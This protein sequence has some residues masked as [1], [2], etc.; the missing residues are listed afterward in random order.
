M[1]PAL[2][3]SLDS[4]CSCSRICEKL[5]RGLLPFDECPRMFCSLV[6]VGR[7]D[8]RWGGAWDSLVTLS[9]ALEEVPNRMY[10]TLR[11][12]ILPLRLEWSWPEERP[13]V[14]PQRRPPSCM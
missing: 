10:K 12:C 1:E 9:A 3:L 8:G 6:E 2:S 4:C 7:N 5:N 14:V 13:V 11:Q